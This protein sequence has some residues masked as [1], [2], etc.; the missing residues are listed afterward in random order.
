VYIPN[1]VASLQKHKVAGH[2]YWRIVESRR[3]DGKPRPVPVMQLGTADALLDRLLH[4]PAGSLRLRSFGHGDVAA[5]W[6]AAQRL[7]VVSVIDQH[8]PKKRRALSVGQT[9][10]LAALNR[11][12]RPRSKRGFAAWAATTSIERF[13]PRLKVK[14]LTSQYFWDQMDLVPLE[15]LRTIEE[16][17]T[18]RVVSELDVDLDTLFYDTTNY[19]TYV[20]TTNKQSTLTQRGHSKQ[21][22][23]DLRLFG[24]ALLV[25]RTK[26]LPLLSHVYEGNRVDSKLFPEALTRIRERLEKLDV[27]LTQLTVV[28]DKGNLSKKNQAEVDRAPFGYVASLTPHHHPN[29]MAIP[30]AS[31]RR[32]GGKGRLA[33]VRTL[34]FEHEVWGAKR[35]V[36]LL[37]SD[38]LRAGQMRGLEQH[39]AKRIR[40]LEAWK[41]RLTKPRSGPRTPEAVQKQIE[42]LRSGQYVKEVLHVT[43]D[44]KRKGSSRLKYWIDEAAR[45]HLE[46][47]VFG[48]RILMTDRAAWSTEEVIL[49]YRGQSEV[50]AVFRQTKDDE[51]MAI[52]P[53]Y[54]WTDQKIHVHTF[55]CLL[56]LLLGR[57]IEHEARKLGR[58]E[59]LSGLLDELGRIR[60]AMVLRASGKK[61]GRPR[62][63]WQLEETDEDT[64]DLFRALVPDKRPFVYTPASP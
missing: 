59:G 26:G 2:T 44:A 51:H 60:L 40:E 16:D 18:R 30:L 35:T 8:V 47:E 27:D 54:H 49:A 11:A 58:T 52:R 36:V 9:L 23:A 43:Y 13:V 38:Q 62:A 5:L 1:I 41:E 53:Q 34:R 29:L 32:L 19:F 14:K 17:L 48:K 22:R 39:L 10:L 31:Y 55:I 21:K 42:T 64:L 61:G 7:D 45:E 4:A 63:E 24:L 25:D 56:A 20:A 3:I 46:N 28:Y 33:D 50:E 6:A 57:V 12:I 37:L 15:A